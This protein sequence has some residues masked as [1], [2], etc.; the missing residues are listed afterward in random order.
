MLQNALRAVVELHGQ[1]SELPK[2]KILICKGRE[3]VVIK[4]STIIN[5]GFMFIFTTQRYA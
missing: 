3:D 2:I 4:V 1:S 5:I